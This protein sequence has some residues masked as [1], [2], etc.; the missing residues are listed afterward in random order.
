MIEALAMPFPSTPTTWPRTTSCPGVG[1]AATAACAVAR[2]GVIGARATAAARAIGPSRRDE[3]ITGDES[4]T[5]EM[6]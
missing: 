4:D 2:V 6:G 3:E 1:D 5:V